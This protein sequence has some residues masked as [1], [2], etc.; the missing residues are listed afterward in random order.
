MGKLMEGP[1][2]YAP[3]PDDDRCSWYCTFLARDAARHTQTPMTSRTVAL[4]S[5][6]PDVRGETN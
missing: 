5:L 3:L 6:A 2:A 4:F 1:A